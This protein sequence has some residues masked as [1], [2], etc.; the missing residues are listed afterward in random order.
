VCTIS[1]VLTSHSRTWFPNSAE[2]SQSPSGLKAISKSEFSAC[3]LR[4]RRWVSG[5]QA[6]HLQVD[7]VPPGF[8]LG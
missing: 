2:A 4:T 1:P 3:R 7:G 5:R 8:R 6:N